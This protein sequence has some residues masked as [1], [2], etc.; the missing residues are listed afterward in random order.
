MFGDASYRLDLQMGAT[1]PISITLRQG[2]HKRWEA[3]RV[4]KP[5]KIFQRQFSPTAPGPCLSSPNLSNSPYDDKLA[6]LL[7]GIGNCA[8]K[9]LDNMSI[10]YDSIYWFI[11]ENFLGK[12]S[13]LNCWT[14]HKQSASK[15]PQE[16]ALTLF[17][18]EGGSK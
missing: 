4:W 1:T 16:T 9:I 10:G 12:N 8:K 6:L 11:S 13:L 3:H 18:G 17:W 2:E 14:L 5:L 15:Y 7:D